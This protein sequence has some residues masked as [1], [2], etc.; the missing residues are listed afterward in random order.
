M[1]TLENN[2][3]LAQKRRGLLKAKRHKL[4]KIDYPRITPVKQISAVH[5]TSIQRSKFH[6]A[7]VVPRWILAEARNE[8]E[9]G[10]S[11][12]RRNVEPLPAQAPNPI[13]QI[14]RLHHHEFLTYPSQR[15]LAPPLYSTSAAGLDSGQL[16]RPPA[17]PTTALEPPA[18]PLSNPPRGTTKF[19][20]NRNPSPG[21]RVHEA[22]VPSLP[23][24]LLHHPPSLLLRGGL[25]C[26]RGVQRG[27]A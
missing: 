15:R 5:M 1:K 21:P 11:G 17:P 23:P 20:P 19:H 8:S 7:C 14:Y 18:P 24:S 26:V 6:L 16:R 12:A 25:V 22:A 4:N 13:E 10:P 27:G 3:V 2:D 9:K